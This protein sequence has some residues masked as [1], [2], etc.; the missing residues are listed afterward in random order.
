MWVIVSPTVNL[1]SLPCSRDVD[2]LCDF[3]GEGRF[4]FEFIDAGNN[5]GNATQEKHDEH[6]TT[7]YLVPFGDGFDFELVFRILVFMGVG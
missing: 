1:N 2:L 4:V 5:T 6:N 7:D 3:R